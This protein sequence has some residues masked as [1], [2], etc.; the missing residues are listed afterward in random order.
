MASFL[1]QENHIALMS[2][3]VGTTTFAKGYSLEEIDKNSLNKLLLNPFKRINLHHLVRNP[4]DRVL[5]VFESKTK[6]DVENGS[7]NQ[8]CQHLLYNHYKGPKDIQAFLLELNFRDFVLN[9]LPK[10]YRE[11]HHYLPQI[12]YFRERIPWAC[13]SHPTKARSVF[14]NHFSLIKLDSEEFAPWATSFG[15]DPTIILN[16]SSPVKTVDEETL[17]WLEH[18]LYDEDFEI[19]GYTTNS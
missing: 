19:L 17:W 6:K 3:K 8:D 1:L 9:Y 5:S 10:V 7:W 16:P 15:L 14:G 11:D 12:D 13:R 18:E 2:N 4:L